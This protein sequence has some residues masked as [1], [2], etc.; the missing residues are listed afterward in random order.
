MEEEKT[1]EFN[2]TKIRILAD[3]PPSKD[4]IPK[5]EKALEY[6]ADV[7]EIAEDTALLDKE[8]MKALIEEKNRA[9]ARSMEE[10]IELRRKKALKEKIRENL[11]K[12]LE[13]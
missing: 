5:Y 4:L 6:L 3:T 12:A 9:K 2:T 10:K 11:D 8:A 1:S 7:P 13:L